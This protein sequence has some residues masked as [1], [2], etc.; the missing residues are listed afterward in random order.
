MVVAPLMQAYFFGKTSPGIIRQVLGETVAAH[1]VTIP[2]TVG[3][4]GVI[5]HVAVIANILIVPLVPLAMLLTFV[6]GLAGLIMP[7]LAGFIGQPAS[8]LLMYM[9][10]TSMFL[11]ALPW[12][13]MQ[14]S[15]PW[16][17]WIIYVVLLELVCWWMWRVTKLEFRDANPI[18]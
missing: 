16:W 5:S 12:A 15:P 17:L 14:W 8:W 4:F 9:T 2:I 6:T 7:D 11:A 10:E 3:A 13:Q 18:I 1:I